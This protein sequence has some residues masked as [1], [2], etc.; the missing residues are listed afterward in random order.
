MT[1]PIPA[2]IS[3]DPYIDD[4]VTRV[5]PNYVDISDVAQS[6]SLTTLISR[7]A[8][9]VLL[10]SQRTAISDSSSTSLIFFD[11]GEFEV[12]T[13]SLPD[14]SRPPL[15]TLLYIVKKGGFIPLSGEAYVR[16]VTSHF[17]LPD[18][19]KVTY[20]CF[21]DLEALEN[22]WEFSAGYYL[23]DESAD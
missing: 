21:R 19:A 5:R 8:K 12:L 22:S 10:A 11:Y 15:R 23:W 4:L 2:V 1:T 20:A 17:T 3:L 13:T 16:D 6:Q 14:P 7:L 9:H 18:L